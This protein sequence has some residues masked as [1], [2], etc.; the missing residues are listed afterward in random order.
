MNSKIVLLILT[1][2]LSVSAIYAQDI[3]V[4]VKAP[5][6]VSVGDRFILRFIVEGTNKATPDKEGFKMKNFELGSEK[7]SV[8]S[9]SSTYFQ[10]GEQV[11]DKKLIFSYELTALKKGIFKV[12][13]MKFTVDD[14]VYKSDSPKIRV[15]ENSTK[16]LNKKAKEGEAFIKTIVSKNKANLKDT[17]TV[18]YRLYTTMNIRQVKDIYHPQTND[19]YASI[20]PVYSDGFKQEKIGNKEYNVIDIRKIILQPRTLGKKTFPRSE[21]IVEFLLPTGRQQTDIYGNPYD[22]VVLDTKKLTMDPVTIEV[23]DLIGL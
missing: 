3:K 23:L 19:F 15:K 14:Q 22:E 5:E 8:T 1:V 16:E 21:A 12:P 4:T 2:F 7:P 11:V 9:S 18:T 20:I 13:E 6:E 10:S 17:L